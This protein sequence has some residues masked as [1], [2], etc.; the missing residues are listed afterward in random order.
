MC[1]LLSRCGNFH[2]FPIH[3]NFSSRELGPFPAERVTKTIFTETYGYETACNMGGSTRYD[4]S[5]FGHRFYTSFS[6]F[7]LS[8][9]L[10]KLVQRLPCV[11]LTQS[12]RHLQACRVCFFI[13]SLWRLVKALSHT[14]RAFHHMLI[15]TS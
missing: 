7:P 3:K 11:P 2:C 6:M 14:H 4:N 12:L 13:E 8:C 15:S 1:S 5:I 10:L 9:A